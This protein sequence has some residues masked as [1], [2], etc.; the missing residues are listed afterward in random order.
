MS[1]AADLQNAENEY[2]GF[3]RWGRV[4]KLLAEQY[5]LTEKEVARWLILKDAHLYFTSYELE[6]HIPRAKQCTDETQAKRVIESFILQENS[7]AATLRMVT[8]QSSA[9]NLNVGVHLNQLNQFLQSNSV[10]ELV[11]QTRTT[12]NLTAPIELTRPQQREV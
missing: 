7:F 5:N 4:V 10:E 1:I 6:P 2:N 12:K 9:S 3:I 8:G 11:I